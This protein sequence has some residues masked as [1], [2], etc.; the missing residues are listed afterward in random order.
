MKKLNPFFVIGTIGM[1]LTAV[2]HIVFA[3]VLKLSAT[4]VFLSVY[5]IFMAF[6]LIG[7]AQLIKQRGGASSR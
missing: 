4:A 3:L 6:L 2:L 5:P 1:L 7:F